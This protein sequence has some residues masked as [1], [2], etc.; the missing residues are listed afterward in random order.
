MLRMV[1]LLI[2]VPDVEPLA[3]NGYERMV[4][5]PDPCSALTYALKVEGISMEPEYRHGDIIFVDPE[6]EPTHGADVVVRQ[7]NK[8]HV[9]KR[10]VIEGKTKMLRALNADWP[11]PRLC[12][13]E[14]GTTIAG[15]VV[16]QYRDRR[17]V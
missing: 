2:D 13:L 9:F 1:P 5:C 8:E 15:V 7:T 17:N 11:G 6:V 16:Y 10:L 14:P 3:A 4:G 12:E